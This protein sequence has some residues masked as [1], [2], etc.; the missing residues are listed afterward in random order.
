MS[1]SIDQILARIDVVRR[2][3]RGTEILYIVLTTLLFLCGIACFVMAIVSG[4]F[5]WAVPPVFTTAFLYWPLNQIKD[6]R[7][8]NI[9][10]ACAPMLITQLPP[11]LAAVEIQKLLAVLYGDEK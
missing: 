7:R 8:K 11:E 1:S 3:N 10:L 5:G 9:A 2:D 6:I 4:Q